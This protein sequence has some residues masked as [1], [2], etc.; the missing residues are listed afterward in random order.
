[1]K[2]IVSFLIV[3]FLISNYI[4]AQN[5]D[6]VTMKSTKITDNI[7]MLQGAG[8][9]IGLLIGE[10]G[11]FMI[12]DQYRELS[13]KIK[14][15]VTEITSQPI[16][17]VFNTHWHFDHA[18]SNEAFGEKAQIIAHKNVRKRLKEDHVITPFGWDVKALTKSGWPVITFDEG[19]KMY[20]N[21][22]EINMIHGPAA[23]TDGDAF[24]FFK[25][26]NVIHTGDIFVRYG[27]PFIDAYSG[28][29]IDGMIDILE[30]IIE[31]SN[32]E[33]VIIPGHGALSKQ[34][35]VKEVRNMLIE[36]KKLILDAKNEG[37]S[38]EELIDSNIL[39][40]YS[41]RWSGNFIDTGLFIQLVYEGFENNKY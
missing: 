22:E 7:Y 19:F 18:G 41:E 21:N 26:A 13:D 16:K 39:S 37:R 12:D 33:T 8:G 11:V 27:F 9:N 20:L 35:D 36:T 15:A 6:N 4:T 14:N 30:K 1:M 29:S 34:A 40:A 25:E 23:H 2:Q 28:G 24:V 10:D 5:F 31:L 17:Y 38:K 32:N 3:F